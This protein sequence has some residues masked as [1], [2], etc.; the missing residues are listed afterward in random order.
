[1]TKNHLKRMTSPK[2]W[3]ISRK[4]TVFV[5]RPQ[6]SGHPMEHSIPV[7]I[8]LK[9]VLGYAGTT[10]AVRFILN[11]QEVLVNGRR[12]RRPE[13][14]AG[15]MDVVAFPA[16]KASFRILINERNKLYTVPIAGDEAKLIPS[17]VTTKTAL[18]KGKVQLGF[19][20]GRALLA[21]K[22][23]KVGDTLLLTL[24][25]KVHA[26]YPLAKGAFVLVTGGKHVGTAGVVE[27]VE[28]SKIFL[29]GEPAVES[30]KKHAFVLGNGASAIKLK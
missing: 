20:N 4:E 27:K 29:A 16:A 13:F 25:N 18:P 26:H 14:S 5:V 11:T 12:V 8:L 10:R 1:M 17:K 2:T 24:E 22:E 21:G 19:H 15:L 23:Q 28:G 6:P 3:P 30:T 7:S 9:D